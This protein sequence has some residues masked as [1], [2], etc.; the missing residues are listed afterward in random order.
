MLR[1]G[2]LQTSRENLQGTGPRPG[3]ASRPRDARPQRHLDEQLPVGANPNLDGF[4]FAARRACS[5]LRDV[6][7]DT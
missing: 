2:T 5:L 4:A 1:P 3:G 7:H 6:V